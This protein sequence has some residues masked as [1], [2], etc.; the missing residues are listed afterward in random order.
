GWNR[1]DKE[2]LIYMPPVQFRYTARYSLNLEA[3]PCPERYVQLTAIHVL[4]QRWVPDGVDYTPPPDGYLRLDAEAAYTTHIRKQHLE[5]GLS[6]LNLLNT[7][8][9]DYLN[10]LRY[11]AEE[12]GRNLVIRIRLPLSF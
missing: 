11:F 9:R 12:P 4:R 2:Y 3:L 5:I 1:R 6:V 8:Y 10:R 7:R